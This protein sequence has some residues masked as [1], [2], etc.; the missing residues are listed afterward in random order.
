MEVELIATYATRGYLRLRVTNATGEPLIDYEDKQIDLWR[1]SAQFNRPKWGIYR[2]LRRKKYL[3]NEVDTMDFA[4]F[5]IQ[6][7]RLPEK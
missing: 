1:E 7:I 4:D 5:T 2:S 3:V 6:K